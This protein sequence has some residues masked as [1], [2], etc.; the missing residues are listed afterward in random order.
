MLAILRHC[1]EQVKRG[2]LI[3][4]M[5]IAETERGGYQAVEA[6]LSGSDNVAERI[7]RLHLL[8]DDV[9]DAAEEE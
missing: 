8:I 9:K 3:G 1:Y 7:G 6:F 5:I 2:E 4:L